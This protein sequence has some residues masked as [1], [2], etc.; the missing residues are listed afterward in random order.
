MIKIL[1]QVNAN[2]LPDVETDRLYLRQRTS[3]DAEDIFAYA[4]LPEVSVPA[5]FP[6]VETLADELYYI[7]HI[8]PSNLAKENIPSGY[9]ITLKGTDKVIGS[10]DFPHR[11]GDKTLEIGYLLHPDYWGQGIVPEAGR[12]MLK[13]GFELLGLDKIILICYDYNKQ[14]QAVAR[15]LG[16][17]LETVSEEI[18][19]PAGRVCR[20]ETWGL[21]REEWE[22]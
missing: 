15:K 20:D 13:V 19:D 8:Y 4:R 11:H 7:E 12:A 2:R 22:R 10:I 3:A 1:G 17:T 9:G 5:G 21:L 14:S 6:A 16:F 18:Q